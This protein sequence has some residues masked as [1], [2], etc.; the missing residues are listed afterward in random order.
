MNDEELRNQESLKEFLAEAEDIAEELSSDLMHL[1]ESAEKGAGAQADPGVLNS[2]FRSAHSLKG[3]SGMFGFTPMVR[4]SHNLEELLDA[5]RLGKIEFS[6]ALVDALFEALATL[7]TL[8]KI[9]GRGEDTDSVDITAVVK[10]LSETLKSSQKKDDQSSLLSGIESS[11]LDVLTEYEEYRLKENLKNDLNILKVQA[12]FS[13][14]TFDQELEE[15]SGLLKGF[16]EIIT[17]LPTPGA[18]LGETI[19]FDIVVATKS[20]EDDLNK[21]ID[22]KDVTVGRANKEAADGETELEAAEKTPTTASIITTDDGLKSLTK[23]VRV[24]IS[25]LDNLMNI[26][27]ELIL[28]KG[29]LTAL[30]DSMKLKAETLD[31][32]LELQKTNKGLD[33]MLTSLQEGI[34]E[35]RMVPLSQVFDKLSRSVRKIGRDIGKEVTL[36]VK[37]AETTIDKLIVEEL[38]SPLMHIIRNSMDHGIESPEERTRMGKAVK[39]TIELNAYQSGNHVVLEIQDDGKGLDHEKILKKAIEKG[40]AAKGATPRKEEIIDFMFAPGFST[41]EEVSDLSGR[42][43]GLDVV[44]QNISKISGIVEIDSTHGEG[45]KVTLTLPMTLAIIQALIIKTSG[46]HFAIPLNP[47]IE[48]FLIEDTHIETIETKEFVHLRD[49]TIPLIRLNELLGLKKEKGNDEVEGKYVV[50]VGL[51]EK[52]LGLVVDDLYGQQD[53]VLKSVG[54]RF[55]DVNVIAGATEFRQKIVLALDVGGIID[56]CMGEQGSKNN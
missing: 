25:K 50:V 21:A 46:H 56:Q 22:N 16:G 15:L 30:T 36:K 38:S 49:S 55:N 43:V 39:G 7:N 54:K 14:A 34:M 51:A 5:L 29:S 10:R 32:G 33:K 37:G 40:L 24:D 28:V 31:S 17:T 42:G 2:V 1:A 52:K 47:I 11:I 19:N 41:A 44:K 8:L 18:A 20:V 26:V 35:A 12:S 23:T 48:N 53:I 13:I 27:G 3:L 45:T 9:R 4:I 6:A